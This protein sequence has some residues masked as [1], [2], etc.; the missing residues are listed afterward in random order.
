[1][2]N[3]GANIVEQL[4]NAI[5]NVGSE[6]VKSTLNILF[7]RDFELYLVSLEL[8]NYNDVVEDYFT[9]P[10]N[11]QSISKSEM[12][13][14]NIDRTYGAVVVNKTGSFTPQ[15]I[16]LKGNFGKSFK[17]LVR[18]KS[19]IPFVS[20]YKRQSG[21]FSS[22]I[23]NGYGSFKVLQDICKRSNDLDNGRPKRLY[24]HNFML[25]ESYLVE[26]LDFNGDMNMSSNMIWN[27]TLRMKILTPINV[28]N[29]QRS[30]QVLSGFTQ[31]T[32][33]NTVKATSDFIS[34][35]I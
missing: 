30:L 28:E 31:K 6:S 19:S 1:M 35:N 15:D 5:G 11:P 23:K 25:G 27:Y 17:M 4:A 9:F 26:V 20:I 3:I 12:Y 33:T 13:S 8:T 2:D 18:N 10:I 21:E 29:K 14:K 7:P 24:F 22:V 34:T 16:T 32:I